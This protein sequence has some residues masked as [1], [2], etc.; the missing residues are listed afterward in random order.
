MYFM[1]NAKYESMSVVYYYAHCYTDIVRMG[2]P[3]VFKQ[4]MGRISPLKRA[5]TDLSAE[6][7]IESTSRMKE[8]S[9]GLRNNGIPI[10]FPRV[11]SLYFHPDAQNGDLP[12]DRRTLRSGAGTKHLD[13]SRP[14]ASYK[15]LRS[16]SAGLG[17]GF[18]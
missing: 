17:S 12:S 4:S 14:T 7:I 5:F 1:H 8:P 15:W 6:Q 3:I 9:S 11:N 13:P 18:S 10:P 2:C 16:C